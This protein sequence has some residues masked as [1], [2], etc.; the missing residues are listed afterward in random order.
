MR[1]ITVVWGVT[2]A[3]EAVLRVILALTLPVPTFLAVSSPLMLV[4]T[5]AVLAWTVVYGRGARKRVE[6][7][8][9]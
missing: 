6:R 3:F 7:N 2:Y 8:A 9:S 4:V 5:V 1:L